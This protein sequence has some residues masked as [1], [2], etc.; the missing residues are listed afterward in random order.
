[1]KR[2]ERPSGYFEFFGPQGKLQGETRSC[3]HCGFTWIYDPKAQFERQLGL[4]SDA[5]TTRGTCMKCYGLVCTR[6]ECMAQGCRPL[7]ARIE[8]M[9]RSS[10]SIFLP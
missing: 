5:P 1:M 10:G 4:R 2:L 8:D 7:M 3:V 9:E 6:P